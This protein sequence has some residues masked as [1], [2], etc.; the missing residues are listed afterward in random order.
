MVRLTARHLR[1]AVL[2]ALPFLVAAFWVAAAQGQLRPPH[3]GG[4]GGGG[5]NGRMPGMGGPLF[6][7]VW[8]CGKCG[9]E[10]GRGAF[11]PSQC[12]YCG[13]RLI[14]GVGPADPQ[15]KNGNQP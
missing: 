9:K 2:P 1:E 6:E 8:T 14:N 13:V 7:T 4:S 15:Y 12:P 3:G 5:F 11:P 10:I